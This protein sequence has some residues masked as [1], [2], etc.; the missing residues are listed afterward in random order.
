[1]SGVEMI[2]LVSGYKESGEHRYGFST[3]EW[4]NGIYFAHVRIDSKVYVKKIVVQ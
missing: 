1:L 4:S 3:D 2:N